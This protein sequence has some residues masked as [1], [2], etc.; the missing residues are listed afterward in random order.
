LPIPN[1]F[2]VTFDEATDGSLWYALEV[3]S[4]NTTEWTGAVSNDW[5]NA[6]NW[7]CNQV[8][9]PMSK[10][11]INNAK[12]NYPLVTANIT[13]NSLRVNTGAVFNVAPGVKVITQE[14]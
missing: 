1:T 8:P 7:C 4:A 9:G 13:I 5:F 10:V 2:Y 14:Q 6:A 3:L 12:P 11:V